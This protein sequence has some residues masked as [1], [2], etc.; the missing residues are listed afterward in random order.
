MQL[1]T[2][3]RFLKVQSAGPANTYLHQ[4]LISAPRLNESVY[5]VENINS[6]PI[7]HEIADS[8]FRYQGTCHFPPIYKYL[9]LCIKIA[10]IVLFKYEVLY[11]P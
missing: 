7:G 2:L 3:I 4:A 8:A 11:S 1:L 5:G 9:R 10:Q 6:A